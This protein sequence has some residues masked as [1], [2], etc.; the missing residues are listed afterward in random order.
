MIKE[1]CKIA[2]KCDV[3]GCHNKATVGLITSGAVPQFNF[4]DGCAKE[5]AKTLKNMGGGKGIE[6]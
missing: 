1:K 2:V 4:C 3:D 6:G 5:I